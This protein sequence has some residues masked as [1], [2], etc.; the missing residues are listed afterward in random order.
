M[1]R[2]TYSIVIATYNR[3]VDLERTLK[4]VQVQT[5]P[6]EIVVVVDASTTS[7]SQKVCE[8]KWNFKLI[9]EKAL[10]MSA[11]QQRNQGALHI[12]SDLISFID[13][14]VKL[15]PEFYEKLSQPFNDPEIG[16]VAGRI[17]DMEQLPPSTAMKCYYRLQA[18]YS[19]SNYGAKLFGPAINCLPCYEEEKEELIPAEW[20]NSCGVLYRRNLFEK[21]KFPEF[22]GY[23][24]G[25]DVH[26]SSRIAKRAK[27][28]FHANAIYDHYPKMSK[29]KANHTM[30]ERMHLRHQ[31]LIAHEIMNVPTFT[32]WW[33]LLIHRFYLTLYFFK[34]R[35]QGWPAKLVGTW[36]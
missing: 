28:Y 29:A 13:D 1:E 24:Y 2:L 22:T 7:E 35:P 20:L 6:T 14:D 4:S 30:I 34:S 5:H 15:D 9:Y 23:S 27:I 12:T 19:H 33:K 16:G 18:G 10:V 17:R 11:A 3:P 8:Q 21:E 25:E 36:T 31:K 26:L 32:L